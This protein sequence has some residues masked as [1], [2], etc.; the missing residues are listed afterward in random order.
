MSLLLA[1]LRIAL[2]L[3]H[4]VVG[5]AIAASVFPWL[6]Q[7]RRN[8]IIRRWSHWLLTLCGT[9]LRV[10]GLP[11]SPE[12]AQSGV[13]TLSSGRLVL[14]NHI[15]WLDIFALNASMPSRFVAKSEIGRWPLLGTLVTLVGTLYIERGR[16]HAVAAMN[17]RVRDHLQ[18]GETVAIFPEGTT[19]DGST[20]LPFHSNL[21]APAVEVGCDCW[22][23]ALR[24][25]ANGVR[26]TAPAFVG[27]MGFV[28]SLWNILIARG[29]VVEV[30]FLAP[31]PTTGDRNRHHIVEAARETIAEYLCLSSPAGRRV[32]AAPGRPVVGTAGT[33]LETASDSARPA[34]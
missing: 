17:H 15:S 13:E 6:A 1:L 11:L 12:L 28:N 18:Q 14:A 3:L 7:G 4:V 23:V 22:P 20:L 2:L 21:V 32:R 27:E 19:T 31:V 33:A 34:R 5:V 24:Y 25:T 29:L 26:S 9:R 16:R 10:T 8:R 30:A